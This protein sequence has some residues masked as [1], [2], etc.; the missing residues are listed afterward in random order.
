VRELFEKG[1]DG[2]PRMRKLNELP[3]GI[4]AALAS[5]KVDPDGSISEFKIASRN[6]A[7]KTL[8]QSIGAITEQ[9]LHA[10]AHGDLG[11]RLEAAFARVRENLASDAPA[12]LSLP[13]DDQKIADD[14]EETS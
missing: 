6:D 8:L 5:V 9:H 2:K 13:A 1:P 3:D 12:A 4:A 11:D 7:A 14:L 10:H